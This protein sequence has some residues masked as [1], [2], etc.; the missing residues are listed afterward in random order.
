ME[1]RIKIPKSYT[2]FAVFKN[3]NLIFT[4]WDYKGTEPEDV[5]YYSDMDI[6]DM[7]IDVKSTKVLTTAGLKKMGIDPFDWSNWATNEQT[8][9]EVSS[10]QKQVRKENTKE[11]LRNLRENKF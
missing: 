6:K 8:A 7:D 11:Y 1:R 2:H 4:G 3:S 10:I 9:S 5:R